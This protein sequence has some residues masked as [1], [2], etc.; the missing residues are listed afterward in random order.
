[1]S[2]GPWPAPPLV[3]WHVAFASVSF[4]LLGVGEWG[5]AGKKALSSPRGPRQ[6]KNRTERDQQ[7]RE[8]PGRAG[9]HWAVL[10]CTGV[11]SAPQSWHSPGPQG[12]G[13]CR[14]QGARVGGG[15]RGTPQ[16]L[17]QPLL[18]DWLHPPPGSGPYP[19]LLAVGVGVGCMLRRRL[20]WHLA[21]LPAGLLQGNTGGQGSGTQRDLPSCDPP[22]Q[23]D[24]A[25]P[26]GRPT[27][28]PKQRRRPLQTAAARGGTPARCPHHPKCTPS[29]TDLHRDA[30][31]RHRRVLRDVGPLQCGSCWHVLRGGRRHQ[32]GPRTLIP[33]PGGTKGLHRAL[34]CQRRPARGAPAAV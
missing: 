34:P 23:G 15:V 28:E 3:P 11:A 14:T 20:H 4:T 17:P 31:G 29:P 1:M 9:L 30:G 33:T 8:G 10:G 5:R 27:T 19:A 24:S 22:P 16:P 25:R 21:L 13:G 7:L 18:Q 12:R 6:R 2:V 26:P 32:G